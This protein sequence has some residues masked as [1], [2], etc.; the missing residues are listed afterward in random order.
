[1]N[2]TFT[3]CILTTLL[4]ITACSDTQSSDTKDPIPPLRLEQG[5]VRFASSH[6]TPNTIYNIRGALT[7]HAYPTHIHVVQTPENQW[8]IPYARLV[9]AGK[10]IK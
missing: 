8:I 4:L 7:I 6:S 2:S 3:A 9:Y 1:M 5:Y 10:E